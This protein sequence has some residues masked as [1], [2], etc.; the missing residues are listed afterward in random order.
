[1]LAGQAFSIRALF[2]VPPS[3]FRPRP[4]V[5][6]T[7]THWTRGGSARFDARDERRLRSCLAICFASRRRT[8]R[9]NLRGAGLDVAAV[10]SCLAASAIDGSLRAEAI[11]PDAFRRLAD[12]L[13]EA[14]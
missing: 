3:A 8:L 12:V 4:R 9:N 14:L 2:D 7:V 10:E 6:S 13:A 5:T 1:M 11:S